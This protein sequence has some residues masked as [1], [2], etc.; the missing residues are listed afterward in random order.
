VGGPASPAAGAGAPARADE[1]WRSTCFEAFWGEVGSKS[2]W[3]LNL[4]P[5]GDR[6]NLYRFEDY[7]VPQPPEAS[8]DFTLETL[9][10]RE[11][12]LEATLAARESIG[13]VEAALC[14]VVVT[15]EGP[16]FYALAHPGDKPDFHLRAG[17]GVRAG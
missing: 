14:A 3:E 12:V 13:G 8:D 1:L 16:R 15:G 5:A 10:I 4:S 9:S 2:Y 11:G 6:W 7:R 17:F